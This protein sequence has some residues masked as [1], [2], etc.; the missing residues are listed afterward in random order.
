[1]EETK[2][3]LEHQS[4]QVLNQA[5][6]SNLTFQ[7]VNT[8]FTRTGYSEEMSEGRLTNLQFDNFLTSVENHVDDFFY[9]TLCSYLHV[10]I[11]ISVVLIGLYCM[12]VKLISKGDPFNKEIKTMVIRTV[13]LFCCWVANWLVKT[14]YLPKYYQKKIEKFLEIRN[15]LVYH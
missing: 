4:Q 8:K 10:L 11:V 14:F 13:F 3:N 15:I 5:T 1:M 12:I 7:R 6:A 9:E 2:T